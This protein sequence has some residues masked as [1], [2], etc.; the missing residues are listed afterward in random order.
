M[1][2]VLGAL[3]RF[4]VLGLEN[5]PLG[6]VIIS[7]NHISGFDPPVVGI[8]QPRPV[9]YIAKAEL[10]RYPGFRWVIAKLNA[11]PVH[12]GRPDRRAL[13]ATQEIVRHGGAVV[14][15]PEGHRTETGNLQ[16]PRRGVAFVARV[17]HVPVV[18]VG[19]VGPYRLGRRVTLAFGPPITMVQGE[20]L[21]A[22]SGR[23]MDA[24]REQVRLAETS[25]SR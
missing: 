23:L 19:V 22:F 5:V 6:G 4:R 25:T 14:M 20:S 1:R 10:F 18:P 7:G 16:E 17:A 15:F 24:I 8:M 12:R 11:Y 3:F 13:R 9:W 21:D 2:V